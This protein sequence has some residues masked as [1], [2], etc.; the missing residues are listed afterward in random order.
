MLAIQYFS[1]LAQIL[2]GPLDL[3]TSKDTK[4]SKASSVQSKYV[5]GVNCKSTEGVNWCTRL[6]KT[7]E[8]QE[9]C[10][11][12]SQLSPRVLALI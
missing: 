8:V 9:I 4:R 6:I 3:D 10:F 2:S 7:S 11:L 12:L 1:I 5:G